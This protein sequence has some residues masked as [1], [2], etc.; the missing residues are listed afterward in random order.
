MRH[1][2]VVVYESDGKI[3]EELGE[4]VKEHAWLLRESREPV[5][6]LNLLRQI[7]PSVLL[8]KIERRLID[9]LAF[10]AEVVRVVPDCAVVVVSDVKLESAEQRTN[11]ATLAFDLGARYVMFPPLEES[12]IEDIVI[13]LMEATMSRCGLMAGEAADA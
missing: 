4:L 3:A 7:R 12:L 9:E 1:P 8:L 11:L 10:L 6:C 5:A 2:Q 13:G